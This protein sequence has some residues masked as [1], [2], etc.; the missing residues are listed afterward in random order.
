MSVARRLAG[1]VGALVL[2]VASAWWLGRSP[3][4][5]SGAVARAARPASAVEARESVS[6][7]T[8]ASLA[9]PG[10]AHVPVAIAEAPPP[11]APAPSASTQASASTSAEA[12]E[13]RYPLAL[14]LVRGDHQRVRVPWIEVELARRSDGARVVLRGSDTFV[15]TGEIPLGTWELHARAPEYSHLPAVAHFESTDR[16]EHTSDIGPP[17]FC[18]DVYLY[19]RDWVP[20][21]LRTPDGRAF[22]ELATDR[23]LEPK[24]YFVDAFAVGCSYDADGEVPNVAPEE[25]LARFH[26]PH[27]YQNVELPGGAIGSLEILRPRPFWVRLRVHGVDLDRRFLDVGDTVLGFEL[28]RAALSERFA[29]VRLRLVDL[30]SGE[31]VR[32]AAAELKANTSAHRR[33]DLEH[34]PPDD[35][36]RIRFRDVI[37]GAHDLLIARGANLV[38][39]KLEL[40]PGEPLD[41]GDLPISD[42]PGILLKVVDGEGRPVKAFVEIAPWERGRW[43]DELYHPS[44][45]RSTSELGSY[46]LPLP[47]R[48]SILRV[49]QV[50]LHFTHPETILGEVDV[51]PLL[52]TRNVRIDPAFPPPELELV[53]E[54]TVDVWFE[55]TT[56][57]IEGHQLTVDDETVGLTVARITDPA[58]R[59]DLVP[60]PYVVR[61]W[62][63][64]T[65]LGAIDVVVDGYPVQV[66]GLPVP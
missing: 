5:V 27:G 53:A 32:E 1:L 48:V 16:L 13:P 26:E 59:V 33:H 43:V 6:L 35:V 61:R 8:P 4:G 44:L 64:K 15:L 22:T 42:A 21:V 23:G 36:G 11:S 29:E 30:V 41:L 52:A 39:R 40:A 66:Q 31:P 34:V 10:P 3:A 51:S 14:E 58:K 46:V 56:P 57:W 45:F 38:Q 65:E 28:D 47:D 18:G 19:P 60:G 2:L 24:R 62:S 50:R 55:P 49:R 54:R 37:P 7:A 17:A 20:I 12:P 9:R 63:G 25:P